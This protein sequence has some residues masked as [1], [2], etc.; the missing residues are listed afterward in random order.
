[1]TITEK[2]SY[3]KGLAEGLGL[4][5]SNKQDKILKAIIETLDDIALTVTD[6]EDDLCAVSDQVDEVD[7]DLADL[8]K[9]VYDDED[10]CDGD[11]DDFYE[12]TCPECGETICVD[13]SMLEEDSINCPAC[14]TELEFDFDGCDCGCDDEDCHCEED[15]AEEK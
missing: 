10:E 13:E 7:E 1:M 6:V 14:G 11:D 4:D 5:E 12:V 3:L 9:F 2:V 15:S 8:E